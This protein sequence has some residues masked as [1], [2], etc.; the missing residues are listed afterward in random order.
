MKRQRQVPRDF[1]DTW[2]LSNKGTKGKE[3]RQ[4]KEQTLEEEQML[5]AG[6]RVGEGGARG[7]AEHTE[8]LAAGP[9]PVHTRE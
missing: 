2:N 5:P 4:T 3:G 9:Q 7:S 1:T 8:P 6:R